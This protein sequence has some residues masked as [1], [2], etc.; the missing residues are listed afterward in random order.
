MVFIVSE[1]YSEIEFVVELLGFFKVGD[2][3]IRWLVYKL[4]NSILVI[5]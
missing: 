2:L 4:I 5:M 3:R 1:D